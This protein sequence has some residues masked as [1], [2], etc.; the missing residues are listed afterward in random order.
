MEERKKG[1]NRKENSSAVGR[2]KLSKKPRDYNK[3]RETPRHWET[4][5]LYD[6]ILKIVLQPCDRG[7]QMIGIDACCGRLIPQWRLPAGIQRNCGLSGCRE[8]NL[9]MGLLFFR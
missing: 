8:R 7:E 3:R 9:R 4:M 6:N 2:S 1:E 5:A